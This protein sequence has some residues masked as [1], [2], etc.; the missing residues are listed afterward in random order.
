MLDAS[1]PC[2]DWGVVTTNLQLMLIGP[3]P[4]DQV[5]RLWIILALMGTSVVCPYGPAGL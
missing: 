4:R 2:A 1:S 3:Y 5:W